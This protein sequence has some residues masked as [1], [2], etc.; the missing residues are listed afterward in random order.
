MNIIFLTHPKFSNI[1]SIALY[2]QMIANGMEQ[3]KHSVQVYSPT[4]Y[5]SEISNN[6]KIKKWLG[7]VDQYLIFRILFEQKIK[8]FPKDSLYV[9]CDQ[10]LGMWTTLISKKPHVIHCHDFLA[11]RSALGK[12][13]ENK[14]GSSGKLYQKLI[15]KG[16]SKANNFIS[17]SNKTRTDLHEFL[18]KEPIFSEV[19]YNGLNQNFE[20]GNVMGVRENLED[21]LKINLMQG[22]V[23][24]VGGNQFYKNRTG[25]LQIYIAWREIQ[26]KELPLIMIGS[27]PTD[28]L[29]FAAHKSRFSKDIHF[30]SE[31]S[32]K[33][34]KKF[35]QGASVLLFPSLEEGFGWPIAEAMAS[36][37]PVITTNKEPMSEVGGTSCYYLSRQPI[38]D[39]TK[40]MMWY[41]EGAKI[42]DEVLSLTVEAR[43]NLIVSGLENSRRFNSEKALD[44]IEECYKEVLKKYTAGA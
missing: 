2:T 10:A 42:L 24:H 19:V 43:E 27:E 11:Q 14:V 36:G 22:F 44:K 17:I 9:I 15:R 31:V 41:K 28:T 21:L 18:P 12:I 1:R 33:I 40:K 7:Y 30:I 5:L 20:P 3:R 37:C 4:A 29:K 34:L 23:L 6:P 13:S 26:E 32:N 35:Y 8:K 38:D 39:T 25:V 16:Y